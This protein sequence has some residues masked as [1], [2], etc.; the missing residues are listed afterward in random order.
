MKSNFHRLWQN[1][2]NPMGGPSLE[3]LQI[4]GILARSPLPRS[5]DLGGGTGRNAMHLAANG[6]DATLVEMDPDLCKDAKAIAYER[7]IALSVQQS[8]VLKYEASSSYD[9]VLL[10]GILHFLPTED[11]NRIISRYRRL[12]T[13]RGAHVLTISPLSDEPATSNSLSEQAYLGSMSSAIIKHAYKGW[14]LLAHELY[15]K[16]DDH[17]GENFDVH[18]IEKF[19]YV[20][21]PQSDVGQ[22]VRR[23]ALLPRGT[24]DNKVEELRSHLRQRER[25]ERFEQFYGTPDYVFIQTGGDEDLGL[26]VRSDG[27]FEICV[28]FWGRVKCYFENDTFV[29]FAHYKSNDFFVFE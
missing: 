21:D 19:V 6:F 4:G 7:G 29:A 13:S 14:V 27:A 5:I 8:D 26:I 15:S 11:A 10:L 3:V 9:F 18:A 24:L 2:A 1:G 25:R 12:T 16:T 28:A 22:A 20:P 23:V 17:L